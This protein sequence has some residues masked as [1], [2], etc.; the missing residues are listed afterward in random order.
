[1]SSRPSIR[2][3]VCV[4]ASLLLHLTVLWPAMGRALAASPPGGDDPPPPTPAMVPPPVEPGIERSDA[5]TLTWVGYEEYREHLARLASVD[6]AAFA[7]AP[8]GAAADADAAGEGG[9][10]QAGALADAAAPSI[11]P[12]EPIPPTEPTEPTPPAEMSDAAPTDAAADAAVPPDAVT[13]PAQTPPATTD[14]AAPADPATSGRP[15]RDTPAEPSEARPLPLVDVAEAGPLA[16][17]RPALADAAAT[18]LLAPV[19][20]DG[21]DAPDLR[22]SGDAT[23]VPP[24]WNAAADLA[25]VNELV[26]SLREAVAALASMAP[27]GGQ[28]G[29]AELTV[30]GRGEDA[31]DGESVPREGEIAD[32]ES[33]ATSRIDVRRADLR[34]DRPIAREGLQVKP[35]EPT[36][37]IHEQVTASPRN[38]VARITFGRDGVPVEAI[39]IES[40]GDARIDSAV[41]AS[42]FRWRAAGARLAELPVDGTIAMEFRIVLNGR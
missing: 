13:P 26:A 35:R 27:I 7:T 25:T 29:E 19:A 28:G 17:E 12:L 6:Q 30:V 31:S 2:L 23:E 32:L 9:T 21:V 20:P 22:G 3:A 42:L 4:A 33:P 40:S 18:G 16:R 37:T 10:P 14:D 39:L 11:E 5:S 38:P 34:P 41:E 8:G 24:T 36:F 15:D 1:M